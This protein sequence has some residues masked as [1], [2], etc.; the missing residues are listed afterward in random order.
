MSQDVVRREIIGCSDTK[1]NP[2]IEMIESLVSEAITNDEYV[3]LEG[4]LKR[5]TY[6]QMIEHLMELYAPWSELYYLSVS[7]DTTKCRLECLRVNEFSIEQ[8]WIAE[9]LFGYKGEMRSLWKGFR[10]A[11]KKRVI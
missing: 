7:F 1:N 10:K 9:D 4:I 2:A 8:W 5:S 11:S 6:Y 3:I